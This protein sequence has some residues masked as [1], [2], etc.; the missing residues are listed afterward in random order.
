MNIRICNVNGFI[1]DEDFEGALAYCN[2]FYN[3]IILLSTRE[4]NGDIAVSE[5]NIP[6]FKIKYDSFI[7]KI[8][9]H[10]NRLILVLDQWYEQ[11]ADVFESNN[12]D[13]V[14]YINS[15][16]Y[17][18][19]RRIIVHKESEIIPEYKFNEANKFLFLM[20][21]TATIHRIG[22][23][24]KLKQRNLLTDSNYSFVMPND[25]TQKESKKALDY[26][27]EVEHKQPLS[28]IDFEN[29]YIE[30]KRILDLEYNEPVLN[31]IN[32]THYTGIPYNE[33]LFSDCNFQLISE[34]HFDLTVWLTE[35][36][37][38]S[39]INK[40]PFIMAAYPGFLNKLKRLG[41]KTFE[42][43]LKVP[44][45]D[46]IDNDIDR[47]NSIV[48]NVEYWL[49][50]IKNHIESIKRDVEHNYNLFLLISRQEEVK[51]NKLI[52]KHNLPCSVDMITSHENHNDEIRFNRKQQ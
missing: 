22:L 11:Y 40:R 47:L 7:H 35:K 48:E 13:D 8:K 34:T 23:L 36:T 9:K 32:Y 24:Y 27:L 29:F 38:V 45:Y 21:K 37:W 42:E 3:Y 16:L 46:S 10:T 4:I 1:C 28:Q 44:N 26:M 14:L 52:E 18:T 15:F 39:I 30:N 51:I 5:D 43:Y 17:T 41:F 19:Y 25:F 12:I 50:N 6:N 33:K 20:N 2:G 31:K 49:A